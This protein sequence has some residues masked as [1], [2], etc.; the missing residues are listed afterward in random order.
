MSERR[1]FELSTPQVL[2]GVV[3]ALGALFVGI[4][5]GGRFVDEV[6]YLLVGTVVLG[7]LAALTPTLSRWLRAR[8]G[9]QND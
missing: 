7:G 9:P 8:W 5:F 6:L 2:I 3:V 1:P 4:L